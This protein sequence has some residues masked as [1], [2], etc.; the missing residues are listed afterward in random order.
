MQVSPSACFPAIDSTSFL[1]F[2]WVE[3]VWDCAQ[4]HR[5]EHKGALLLPGRGS[6]YI[7]SINTPWLWE[8]LCLS[9]FFFS[10]FSP[11]PFVFASLLTT[12]WHF[13]HNLSGNLS[14]MTRFF[15]LHQSRSRSFCAPIHSFISDIKSTNSC[16]ITV[17]VHALWPL[18]QKWRRLQCTRRVLDSLLTQ[19]SAQSF[20][21]LSGKSVDLW[22]THDTERLTVLRWDC[23][24]QIC[25]W[26]YHS[27][28]HD[29]QCVPWCWHAN[30]R[31]TYSSP[32]PSCY[33]GDTS[34]SDSCVVQFFK[35]EKQYNIVNDCFGFCPK[36]HRT[37]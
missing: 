17:Y 26:N 6:D 30:V 15:Y 29:S 20:V 9:L 25:H 23:L 32:W 13:G 4:R 5:Q 37:N 18:L 12:S 36:W 2:S 27:S 11:I 7:W 14:L 28:I 3:A 21:P 35:K 19:E 24:C 10:S 22:I 31:A 34:H 1:M 33:H 8:G 16:S